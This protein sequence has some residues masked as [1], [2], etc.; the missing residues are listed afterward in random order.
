VKHLSEWLLTKTDADI[1]T[2]YR[3]LGAC[4]AKQDVAL[5]HVCWSVFLTKKQLWDFLQ[6]QGFM[7]NPMEIYGEMEL[8]WLLEQFFDRAVCYTVA[9]YSKLQ[10]TLSALSDRNEK[11]SGWWL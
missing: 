11:E 8:L 3:E 4:R 10:S 2:R 5:D 6:R 7:R 9:G 1:A